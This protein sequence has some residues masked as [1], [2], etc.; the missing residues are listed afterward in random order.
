MWKCK[1]LS[2]SLPWLPWHPIH[3]RKWDPK[4]HFHQVELLL[5]LRRWINQRFFNITIETG[6]SLTFLKIPASKK[7]DFQSMSVRLVNFNGRS[8]CSGGGWRCSGWGLRLTL[9]SCRLCSFA[10][11]DSPPVKSAIQSYRV[12]ENLRN[13]LIQHCKRCELRLHFEWTKA[14]WKMPKMVQFGEFLKI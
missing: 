7:S 5:D 4:V 6:S 9:D 8:G 12:F 3:L 14:H 10:I 2:F 11:V 13:S 1:S